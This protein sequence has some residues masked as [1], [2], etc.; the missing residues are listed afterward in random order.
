M[1]N[2]I[3]TS[4][5]I[6]NTPDLALVIGLAT[7]IAT[8]IGAVNLGVPSPFAVALGVGV[9]TGLVTFVSRGLS[10]LGTAIAVLVAIF[11]LVT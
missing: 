2:K 8:W 7:T 4:F 6:T 11:T 10:I 1:A 3:K 5:D 9:V